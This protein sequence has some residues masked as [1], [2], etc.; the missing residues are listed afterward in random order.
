[1]C[2]RLRGGKVADVEAGAGEVADLGLLAFGDEAVG[3]A[4]L[5]ENFEGAGV[6]AAG[7]GAEEF[8]SG[9]AFDE[10]DWGTRFVVA[11]K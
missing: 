3:D 1:V 7:A 6:E 5:I 10:G 8:L 11:S 2:W 4:A 9:A